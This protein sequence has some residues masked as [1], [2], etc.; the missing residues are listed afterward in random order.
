MSNASNR[1]AGREQHGPILI[2]ED[3]AIFREGLATVL[4]RE[5]YSVLQANNGQQ[6]L[7]HL[8][9]FSPPSLILLDMFMPV[10]D[11]WVW[12]REC[13]R[14]ALP[15]PPVIIMTALEIATEPWALA[16]GAAGLLKK[17]FDVETLLKEVGRHY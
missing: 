5:G 15:L 9:C 8:Q 13:R 2:V 1:L 12:I 7:D 11:G 16:L 10:M 14:L 4:M 6:A 17:P 3:N